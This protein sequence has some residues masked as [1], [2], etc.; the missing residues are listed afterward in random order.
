[1]DPPGHAVGLH[2]ARGVDGVAPE[3]VGE[4]A[5]ADDPGD[6]GSAVHADADLEVCADPLA[7]A[8]DRAEEGEGCVGHRLQM[9][10]ARRRHPGDDHV[11]V[12]DRLDLLDAVA[13]ADRVELGE[14][15]AQQ[16]DERL[17]V[18]GGGPLGE[19]D[20]IGEENGDGVKALGDPLFAG[21]EAH[22]DRPRQGVEEEP[23]CPIDGGDQLAGA[24]RDL[25]L[26]LGVGPAQALVEEGA[27]D[28]GGGHRRDRLQDL[29]VGVGEEVDLRV[30]AVDDADDRVVEEDRDRQLGEAGLVVGDVARVE[31][32][33]GDP[34]DLAGERHGA[35]DPAA[36]RDPDRGEDLAARRVLGPVGGA[37]D[38]VLAAR[39]EQ[40]D[41]AVLDPEAG[42]R[43]VGDV[44]EDVVEI[45]LRVEQGG[46]EEIDD[47]EVAGL[48]LEL[49]AAPSQGL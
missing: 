31:A 48:G 7:Y 6:D 45:G 17:R 35:D 30:F 20:E 34:R 21:L 3:V 10:D 47:V 39:P 2:P 32:G 27:A 38:Q 11:G 46:G 19:A 18:G 5:G 33:V 49:L 22:R 12:A 42:D 37:L 9:I 16:L 4:F 28:P 13:I 40:V 41:D 1:M 26:E 14:D 24:E 25:L 8:G 44:P 15:L 43:V 23:L 29:L 36:E